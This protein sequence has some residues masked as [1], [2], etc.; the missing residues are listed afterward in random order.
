MNLRAGT[1]E[2]SLR[3]MRYGKWWTVIRTQQDQN[4][5]HSI[6]KG[7][8]YS[9]IEDGIQVGVTVSLQYFNNPSA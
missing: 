4:E 5:C 7:I 8:E 9:W 6:I 1:E 2:T 3:D